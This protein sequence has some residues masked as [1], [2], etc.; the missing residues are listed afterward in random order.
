MSKPYLRSR[1]L[2]PNS[3]RLSR[4]GTSWYPARRRRHHPYKPFKLTVS[5]VPLRTR[6]SLDVAD[7]FDDI[8]A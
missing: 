3:T 2:I 5:L 4:L 6:L 1:A 8:D 7:I